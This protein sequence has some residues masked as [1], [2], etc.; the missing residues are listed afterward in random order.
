VYAVGY[1][2]GDCNVRTNTSA[3]EYYSAWWGCAFGEAVIETLPRKS[4]LLGLQLVHFIPL[5]KVRHHILEVVFHFGFPKRTPMRQDARQS[6]GRDKTT[7]RACVKFGPLFLSHFGWL[8]IK[9][10]N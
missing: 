8:P 1:L 4:R 9:T 6:I 3:A 7:I 10:P 5:S 2:P